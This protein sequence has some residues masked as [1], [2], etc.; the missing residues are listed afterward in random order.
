M[1][2]GQRRKYDALIEQ[3][4]GSVEEQEQIQAVIRAATAYQKAEIL[5]RKRAMADAEAEAERALENDPEQPDYLALY[6]WIL[7]QKKPLTRPL[8]ELVEM[9]DTAVQRSENSVRNRFYRAQLLKRV[10]DDRRAIADFRWIVHTDPRH[11]DA[12]R[13]LRIYEMRGSIPPAAMKTP[14]KGRPTG[15][16]LFG[17]FFKR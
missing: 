2:D 16:G 12:R 7:A 13:E 14:A 4:G 10:G 9:L 5:L 6:A 3:G 8:E 17:K 11:V 15:K 1:D